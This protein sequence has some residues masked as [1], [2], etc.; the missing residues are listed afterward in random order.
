[1]AILVVA[2]APGMTADEDAVL[3]TALNLEGSPPAG[4]WTRMAGP[5]AGGWRIVSL[6]D[7]EEDFERF[8][9]ERLV[10]ALTET[11]RAIRPPQI[12]PIETVLTYTT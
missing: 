3:V 5:T 8:R 2:Q 6:W 10:P 1:M 4:G 11:G 7:S 9:D 12:W